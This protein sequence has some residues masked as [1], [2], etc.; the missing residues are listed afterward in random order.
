[1]GASTVLTQLNY[2][3]MVNEILA[4]NP[5][6]PPQFAQR[7][8]ANCYR[9]IIDRRM[10][11]A[12]FTEGVVGC[13][14]I[15]Q[16]GGT[17]NLATGSATVTGVGTNWTSSLVNQQ[18][19]ISGVFPVRTITAVNSATS[20]TLDLPWQDMPLTGSSY[21]LIQ[22][23]FDLGPGIKELR[24]MLNQFCNWS[25]WVGTGYRE[26]IDA[27]DVW[28]VII[29]MPTVAVPWPSASDGHFR[30]ELWPAPVFAQSFPY[31]YYEQPSD[32]IND[33]DIPIP[34]VRSDVV[35]YGTKS[36][37]YLYGGPTSA[38]YS[39]TQSRFYKDMFDGEID[40]ME[41][42]DNDVQ[43]TDFSWNFRKA[44]F[45]FEGGNQFE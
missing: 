16:P 20:L 15:I 27:H 36:E 14:G 12:L 28:R 35:V 45:P 31:F 40:L 26:A 10:W 17:V 44:P 34:W 30:V 29:G 37:A 39:T 41:L 11:R 43:L 13:P 42:R 23:Y 24:T 5:D 6:I 22:M 38:Y 2:R 3:Q 18:F 4:A 25:L 19:R 32:M 21:Y 8:V 7:M 1:M 33:A 9:R